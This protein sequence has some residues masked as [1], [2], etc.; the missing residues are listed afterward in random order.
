MLDDLAISK[1]EEEI[2]KPD[3][4][5]VFYTDIAASCVPVYA[6]QTWSFL[7]MILSTGPQPL[8]NLRT[9]SIYCALSIC[10]VHFMCIDLLP[11]HIEIEHL[12]NTESFVAIFSHWALETSLCSLRSVVAWSFCARWVYERAETGAGL[13]TR[14]TR[15]PDTRLAPRGHRQVPHGGLAAPTEHP[16]WTGLGQHRKVLGM[17]TKR[18]LHWT[19]GGDEAST[20]PIR[21]QGCSTTQGNLP[22]LLLD[23]TRHH[24]QASFRSVSARLQVSRAAASHHQALALLRSGQLVPQGW[25]PPTPGE[26]CRTQVPTSAGSGDLLPKLGEETAPPLVQDQRAASRRSWQRYKVLV[27]VVNKPLWYSAGLD[28]EFFLEVLAT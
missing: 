23:R 28:D 10:S 21:L 13:E 3:L 9:S 8:V 4:T 20:T 17:E 24:H 26:H 14:W 2:E 6:N 11:F 5:V 7:H 22:R 16:Y 25:T 27:I 15:E 19:R 1:G 12:C 18:A